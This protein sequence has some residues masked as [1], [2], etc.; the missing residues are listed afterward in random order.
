M[1]SPEVNMNVGNGEASASGKDSKADSVQGSKEIVTKEAKPTRIS[2]R[3][4]YNETRKEIATSSESESSDSEESESGSDDDRVYCKCGAPNTDDMIGCDGKKCKYEWFHFKCVGLSKKKVP[5]GKWFC[6]ACRPIKN[7]AGLDGDWKSKLQQ[8]C[9]EILAKKMT[10]QSA[11]QAYGFSME[12]ISKQLNVKP[13]L[14]TNEEQRLVE[15]AINMCKQGHWPMV[16]ESVVNSVKVLLDVEEKMGIKRLHPFKNNLPREDWWE[17]FCRRHPKIEELKKQHESSKLPKGQSKMKVRLSVQDTISKLC[18]VVPQD[19]KKPKHTALQ[20]TWKHQNNNLKKTHQSSDLSPK[21]R[22]RGVEP[23]ALECLE[24]IIVKKQ[25]HLFEKR[26]KSG[27]ESDSDVVYSAW[28]ALKCLCDGSQKKEQDGP[29]RPHVPTTEGD[30]PPWSP[31]P[32]GP[33]YVPDESCKTS[34]SLLVGNL[35]RKRRK[36][37]LLRITSMKAKRRRVYLEPWR[38]RLGKHRRRVLKPW[39]FEVKKRNRRKCFVTRRFENY[40]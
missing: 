29:K 15:M 22:P 5:R 10:I 39:K 35:G 7:V 12:A 25:K 3:K 34:L 1:S 9:S 27:D 40:Q 11:S 30:I 38:Y 13:I 26:F 4:S 19:S 2:P 8:V 20:I 16:R 37:A 18:R 24:A 17:A 36:R 6:E 33:F 21:K 14:T 28:R 32:N 31:C 23:N